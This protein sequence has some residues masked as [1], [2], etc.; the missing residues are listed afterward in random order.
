MTGRR[1]I[2]VVSAIVLATAVLR[3][4]AWIVNESRMNSRADLTAW[5]IDC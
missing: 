4:A 1:V 5:P 3:R 2:G